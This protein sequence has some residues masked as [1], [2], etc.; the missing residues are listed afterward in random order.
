MFADLDKNGDNVVELS[1]WL[2][3][4][5]KVKY[6]GYP[7]DE[8]REELTNIKEGKSWARFNIKE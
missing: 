4:W 2:A 8:I 7:E 3:F 5:E 1:E 6:S